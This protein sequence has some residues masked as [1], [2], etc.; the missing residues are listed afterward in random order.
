MLSIYPYPFLV[1]KMKNREPFKFDPT[2]KKHVEQKRTY[3]VKVDGT[4][5]D[6]VLLEKSRPVGVIDPTRRVAIA[7]SRREDRKEKG[8][9]RLRD[10]P[11]LDR[12]ARIDRETGGVLDK[13]I[14]LHRHWFQYLKLALELESLGK[15]VELVTAQSLI[16]KVTK[17]TS[18]DI[19]AHLKRVGVLSRARKVV[20]VRVNRSKYEKW[21]LPQV[22]S[23]PFNKWWDTH[24]DLFEG[25]S[26]SFL[27]S[28]DEWE[29]DKKFLYLKIDKSSKRLDVQNYLREELGKRL[30]DDG[31]P[32]FQIDGYPRPDQLQNRYNALVLTLTGMKPKDICEHTP[33]YLRATDT[34]SGDDGRLTVPT[35]TDD[36]GRV[37]IQHGNL[38]GTQRKEG[39]HHLVDVIGGR[40]GSAPDTR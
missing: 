15:K 6:V 16:N 38:V 1:R 37:K 26:P 12:D 24:K 13:G 22:L 28:K 29:D 10:E 20:R 3:W 30:S 25:H 7:K 32:S 33:I 35:F 19:P 34:R 18:D 17:S 2:N 31:K 5:P 36:K 8:D 9:T 27:D 40:F 21:D 4:V 39:I 11:H 23:D 14:Q